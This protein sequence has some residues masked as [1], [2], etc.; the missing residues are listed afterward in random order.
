MIE[1]DANYTEASVDVGSHYDYLK[2]KAE[3]LPDRT[4]HVEYISTDGVQKPKKIIRDWV[5]VRELGSGAHGVVW[6]E[7][8]DNGALRAVKHLQKSQ[9]VSSYLREVVAM[10]K[11]SK[12]TT[13]FISDTESII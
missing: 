6:M 4:R 12:V 13:S 2:I 10:T 11:L 1:I 5:Q 9:R 3:V 7:Q 8:A